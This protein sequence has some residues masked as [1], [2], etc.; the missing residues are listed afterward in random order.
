MSLDKNRSL[1]SPLGRLVVFCFILIQMAYGSVLGGQTEMGPWSLIE[2][3]LATVS[4]AEDS[5]NILI[6]YLESA[7][8]NRRNLIYRLAGQVVKLTEDDLSL[9]LMT[10]K[11]MYWEILSSYERDVWSQELHLAPERLATPLAMFKRRGVG[12]W[13]AR[14]LTLLSNI[15][16][17]LGDY[18]KALQHYEALQELLSQHEVNGPYTTVVGDAM[19]TRANLFFVND[20]ALDSAQYYYQ[21]AI[22]Q[23][24]RDTMRNHYPITIVIMNQALLASYREEFGQADSLY[25]VA[26]QRCAA[27]DSS[28]QGEI[29]LERAHNLA[30]EGLNADPGSPGPEKKDSSKLNLSSHYLRLAESLGAPF[31]TRLY[32]Q[33]GGNAQNLA[34]HFYQKND[35]AYDSLLA[36]ASQHY[37][38]A[39]QYS[40]DE[41]NREALPEVIDN[42][43]RLYKLSGL[44]IDI[45]TMQLINTAY[46]QNYAAR[47]VI[48]KERR[49]LLEQ[50]S[51][52]A[53]EEEKQNRLRSI[54]I[55]MAVLLSSAVVFLFLYQRQRFSSLRQQFES[56]MEAL[57]SQMNSHFISNTLNA[58]DSLIMEGKRT[59][60][61]GYI[62]E[63]SRL[64][65]NILNSSKQPFIGLDEEIDILKGYLKFE[66][67]RLG[68]RLNIEWNIDP[69]LDLNAHLVPSLILQPFAENA[70]WHG[71]LNK[72]DRAPGTLTM[73]ILHN[74]PEQLKCIIE[75]DGIGRKQAKELRNNQAIEW[76]SWGMKIT[77]ERIEA[78]KHIRDAEISFEDLYDVQ[79]R[80]V[81]TKVGILLPKH[82]NEI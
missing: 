36:L 59:E 77:N 9:S 39:L 7:P 62:V 43:A 4:N 13:E 15:R 68:D 38:I 10:A 27:R 73:S 2:Q 1:F 18:E 30:L 57:R 40:I 75:D 19:R 47:V 66:K 58:I 61:S 76:Q 21:K 69:T 67:L 8:R 26:L 50:A 42:I 53:L 46:Q 81:G 6:E 79:G 55:L 14:V 78:L 17:L 34:K 35:E 63:F 74:G 54:I 16:Y 48:E 72:E 49:E 20:S 41:N 64:C 82:L 33:L 3:E 37:R 56:R 25:V 44:P 71:I 70:I 32:H 23:Y 12:V 45:E 22:Q 24:Q 29:I 28:L 5:A 51:I 31:P 80:G 11:G 65:R 60:A 52:T